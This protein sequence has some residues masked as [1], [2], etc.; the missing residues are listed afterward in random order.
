M[1]EIIYLSAGTAEV[2]QKHDRK[3]VE[4][5]NRTHPDIR[6]RYELVSWADLFPRVMAYIAAG[7][8]PDVAWYAP[9]QLNDWY[10]M[11]ILEPLDAWLGATKDEY[12]PALTEPGSDVVYGGKMYGAPFTLV[13]L[14][15]VARR[16]LLA[17]LGVDVDG[18]RTWEDFASAAA[19]VTNKPRV[20]GTLFSLGEPRLTAHH[21][22]SFWPSNGLV[23]LTDFDKK[24]A[25]VE[26]LR[27]LDGLFDYMPP[28]QVSWV[29]RDNIAAF[30]SGTIAL[31]ET[32][33]YFHGD[34]M[35]IAPDLLTA[36]NAAVLPVP[37][38]P[39]LQA[40][41]TP[42]YTVGYVM[43][44]DSRNKEAAAEFIR[45]MTQRRV[46]NEWPMNMA[47]KTGLGVEDRV[48]AL[49]PQVRWW[50]ERWLDLMNTT[51]LVGVQ[52]YSP[53]EEIDRIFTRQMLAL[54]RRQLTP[55]RAYESLRNEIGAVIAK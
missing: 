38:G 28:A 42:V 6:V 31:F 13:G 25:Y 5:F 36:K 27:F 30:V 37:F 20:Y 44:K 22:E 2:E 11:G 24:E 33:S 53:A 14:G 21:A 18:I 12:L 46:V 10:R 45:F 16:D 29:H 7:T 26:V 19:K 54:F 32:G 52:P 43:F 15:L 49:G 50:Q 3:W 39:R 55:E 8:P 23:N 35:P 41:V 51:R 9:R 34:L 48:R 4:E 47:P 40:P 1:T 17:P